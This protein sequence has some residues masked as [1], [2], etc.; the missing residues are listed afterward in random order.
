MSAPGIEARA[1][2][3][4][5][6]C[7]FC[8]TPLD[9]H[10]SAG[11]GLCGSRHCR[12]R[13]VH[14]AGRN[15]FSRDW[16]D[17]V[18]HQRHVLRAARNELA[19][20]TRALGVGPERLAYGVVPRAD[21]ES[22]PLPADR[23]AEFA[24]HLDAIIA[25]AFSDATP[26][27]RPV[28]DPQARRAA[29]APEHPL[30]AA[31]CATCRGACCILGG[32]EHAFLDAATIRLHRER[33]PGITPGEVRA[34]FM[35]RVPARSVEASCVYHTDRGCALPREARADICNRYHC[36]PQRQLLERSRMLGAEAAV[37]VAQEP[38][39]SRGIAT[40]DP[41]RG[42]RPVAE[43]AA[44]PGERF[45]DRVEEIALGQMPRH[46]PSTCTSI[47]P[48]P[49]AC[50]WCGIPIDRHKAVSTRC[51]GRPACERR[52]IADAAAEVEKRKVALHAAL[53]ARMREAQA[54]MI[55]EIAAE[56]G[57]PG[58][59]MALGVVPFADDALAPLPDDRRAAFEAHLDGLIAE[60]FAPDAAA[61][62][63]S[64]DEAAGPSDTATP[65]P[66]A[67]TA[68][69]STCRGSCCRGGGERA[70]L[71][72]G[73]V[74]RFRRRHPGAGAAEFRAYYLGILPAHT[75]PGS[76]VYHGARG[77]ALPREARSDTCNGF[78]CL[79]VAAVAEASAGAGATLVIS[80]DDADKARRR[81]VLDGRTGEVRALAAGSET[82]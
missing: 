44:P 49:P 68:A 30:A 10:Q 78:R 48:P 9:P 46:T 57:L 27:S 35:S 38:H 1:R 14:E 70:Y 43:S 69:C 60:G 42:W 64:E 4:L 63:G 61:D 76:C 47:A 7:R 66:A 71:H 2:R 62:A 28:P 13:A 33:N 6:T 82:A 15:V 37:I 40:Y 5:P 59:A 12:A 39:T 17:Y 3:A 72:V 75:V 19:V 50:A 31:A 55:G 77:C 41:G 21:R 67:V 54:S 26:P 11:S 58:E 80:V 52:R 36:N 29:E 53:V 16:W 34:A 8:E 23:R 56:L 73:Q 45:A 32:T 22:V 81:A 51:C 25:E 20:A 65:E 24:A 79:G 18:E 74:Q